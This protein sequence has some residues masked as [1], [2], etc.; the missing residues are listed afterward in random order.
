M[1]AEAVSQYW[2]QHGKAPSRISDLGALV[3]AHARCPK[4]G[5]FDWIVSNGRLLDFNGEQVPAGKVVVRCDTDGH[6]ANA[7]GMDVTSFTRP[8]SQTASETP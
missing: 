5:S 2:R 7:P 4:G 8:L 3:P 6:S 1:V